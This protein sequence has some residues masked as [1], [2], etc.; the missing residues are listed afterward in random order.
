MPRLAFASLSLAPLL[1]AAQPAAAQGADFYVMQYNFGV[2]DLNKELDEI[3]RLRERMSEERDF[4]AGCKLLGSSI[5]H[6]GEAKRLLVRIA[7]YADKLGET[8]DYNAAVEKHNALLEILP[9]QE[10]D[11]ARLCANR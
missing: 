5:Y 11:Y 4:G 10:A 9:V 7:E 3:Q 2:R 8:G 1:L 6:L